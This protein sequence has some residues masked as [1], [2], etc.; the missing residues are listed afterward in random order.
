MTPKI[1]TDRKIRVALVGYGRISKN[2]IQSIEEHGKDLELVVI[3]DTDP[4][5]L[6][7]AATETKVPTYASLED[8]LKH[9]DCDLVTLCTPSGLHP[10]QTVE[11]AN[12][13]RHVITEKPMA[14]SYED[15]LAMVNACEQADRYLFVVKQNRRNATLQLLKQA[16]EQERFGKIYMVSVNVF[17]TR[18][19]TYYDQDDWRGTW[20]M[21]GGAWSA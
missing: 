21:D 4:V 3:C 2:H 13:G 10:S 19:Q 18:P 1:I 14:T 6:D 7:K 16:V 8:M 9:C 11:I 15:G 20:A 17:W 5:A 12:A